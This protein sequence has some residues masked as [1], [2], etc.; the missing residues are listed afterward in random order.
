M[1]P[2]KA[3]YEALPYPPRD[4]ADEAHRLVTGS[5]S[6]LAE[7]DHYVFGARR[8]WSKPFR[9][10]IAG[11]G[12]GDGLVMLA[13]Q[14]AEAGVPAEI[15]YLDL[16]AASRAI[17]EAR[18]A[19]RG[20]AGVHFHTGSLLVAGS[21][22]AF[23]YI[24]CCGVLHHLPDPL[25][26]LRALA[27]ALLPGGGMGL[28]LYG[29]LGRTGVYDMQELLAAL[30]PAE[31][32]PISDR[33]ATARALLKA[34]PP[35]N[36]F[37]RNPFLGDHQSSD[38]G[39]YDLLLHERDRA[40]RV[41]GILELLGAARL[42]LQSFVPALLYDPLRL[43]PGPLA[44]RLAGLAPEAR[45]GLGELLFG[46]LKTHVFYAVAGESPVR[47]AGLRPEAVPVLI[48]L[49]ARDLARH[50]ARGKPLSGSVSG[51]KLALPLPP[52][53]ADVIARVDGRTSL[54]AIARALGLDWPAFETRFAPAF[55]TLFG[56]NQLLLTSPRAI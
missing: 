51:L 25:A 47:P 53:T 5:P 17:A 26:G 35:T 33:I 30:A 52:G 2:V 41:A 34:L 24:D 20:L 39:L 38:E 28:M 15:H 29:E 22:G 21:L 11:G 40:Y 54:G 56:L 27:Q 45:A 1:D 46:S 13:A 49:P 48:E 18:I 16:S 31:T 50:L 19:A 7:I 3:Q 6:R 43:L 36:R 44:G 37:A 32:T 10:L 9:A 55:G 42:R 12:T 8:D 4:P 23:D 14:C